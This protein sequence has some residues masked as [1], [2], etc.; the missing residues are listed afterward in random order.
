MRTS[1]T[2][3]DDVSVVYDTV[4]EV[5][6]LAVGMVHDVADR[7]DVAKR[8]DEGGRRTFL[9]TDMVRCRRRAARSEREG[10]AD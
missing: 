8:E 1:R 7:F 4:S 2:A 6:A 9:I 5:D 10:T 3:S